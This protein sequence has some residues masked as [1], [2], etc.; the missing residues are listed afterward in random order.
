ME[1]VFNGPSVKEPLGTVGKLSQSRRCRHPRFA[2]HVALSRPTDTS[3]PESCWVPH[4]RIP[5]KL[6]RALWTSEQAPLCS[7]TT[8]G[9]TRAM[10]AEGLYQRRYALS[11]GKKCK[12]AENRLGTRVGSCVGP[13]KG[14][15]SD[16]RGSRATVAGQRSLPCWPLLSH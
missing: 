16:A 14:M 12:A 2:K 13:Q 8:G 10:R 9:A 1:V 5:F 3:T 4:W 11:V 15:R 6:S 7:T